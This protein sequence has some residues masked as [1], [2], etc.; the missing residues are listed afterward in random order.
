MAHKGE[1]TSR[2]EQMGGKDPIEYV[3]KGFAGE[4]AVHIFFDKEMPPFR[5]VFTVVDMILARE[6]VE[7]NCDIKTTIYERGGEKFLVVKPNLYQ[8][9]LDNIEFNKKVVDP[10]LKKEVIDAYI[11]VE[12]DKNGDWAEIHGIISWEKFLKHQETFSFGRD[13]SPSV[14]L[15]HVRGLQ[16]DLEY[17]SS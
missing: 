10:K 9:N 17:V 8:R 12:I 6:G 1:E 16:G 11:A 2:K 13:K 14:N 5:P 15:K 7:Y 4:Y 3:K